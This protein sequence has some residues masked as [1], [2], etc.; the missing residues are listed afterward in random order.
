MPRAPRAFGAWWISC[1]LGVAGSAPAAAELAIFVPPP[2]FERTVAL[3]LHPPRH[4][5]PIPE[6]ALLLDAVEAHLSGRALRAGEEILFDATE[7]RVV[8]RAPFQS[9]DTLWLRYRTLPVTLAAAYGEVPAWAAGAAPP[10]EAEPVR[11]A[12]VGSAGIPGAGARAEVGGPHAVPDETAPAGGPK[13]DI[14]GSKSLVVESGSS[15]DAALRQSLDVSASGDLGGGVR[16]TAVLSDRDAPITNAGSTLDLQEID[17]VLVEVEHANATGRLGDYTL[18]QDI[19]RYGRFERRGS[20][21]HVEG[22]FAGNEVLASLAESKGRYH[23]VRLLGQEGRQGPYSLTDENGA[24]PVAVVSGSETVW[25]DGV[26]MQRGESA[27]YSVDYGRG[28][29]TFSP[30][31]VVV[32]DARIVVDFQIATVAY[33]RL[34]TRGAGSVRMGGLRLFGHAFREADDAARPTAGA[35]SAADEERLAGLGDAPDSAVALPSEHT[36]AGGGAEFQLGSVLKLEA[37]GAMSRLDRNRLS[38]RDDGDNRGQA[39]RWGAAL[40]PPLRLGARSLGALELAYAGERWQDGFEP[41]GRTE[42]PLFYEEW[43]LSPTRSIDGR[44]TQAWTLGLKPA[45]ALRVGGERA[46]LDTDDGFDAE[47]WRGTAEWSGRWR[48]RLRLERTAS[49]DADTAAVARPDGY[50][51]L[52]AYE[53][54]WSLRPDFTPSFHWQH[55]EFVPPG[56]APAE[57]RRGWSTGLRGERGL[58]GWTGSFGLRRDWN[59]TGTEWTDRSRTRDWRGEVRTALGPEASASLGLGRRVTEAAGGG[60]TTADNGFGRLTLGT[61]GARHEAAVEWTAEGAPWRLPEL[62]LVGEGAGSFDSLGHFTPGG[63]YRLE[64]REVVDSLRQLARGRLAYRAEWSLGSGGGG[65]RP[66]RLMTTVQSGAAQEGGLEPRTFLAIPRVLMTDRSIVTGNFLF[67]QEVQARTGRSAEWTLRLERQGRADRQTIGYS[68]AQN[69]WTEE[70]RVRWRLATRWNAEARATGSQRQGESATPSTQFSRDLR[71]WNTEGTLSFNPREAITVA[72]SAE[73]I[74]LTPAREPGLQAVRCGPRVTWNLGSR[75][76]LEGETR[77]APGLTAR[78]WPTLVPSEVQAAW[79][80]LSC[81][82]DFSYR[83]RAHGFLGVEWLARALPGERVTHTA[84]AEMR[85]YF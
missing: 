82:L 34:A 53:T 28:T 70:L 16:L 47:R 42:T 62:H 15:R 43:G 83:L 63:G 45:A 23:S 50:R 37:E 17:Q 35:L 85:A 40:T 71:S 58:W 4:S 19:G 72:G 30:R 20:G 8:L 33:T 41:V 52:R 14:T 5:Y 67:R 21:A 73:W 64:Y 66:L 12:A 31:R 76:R 13:L 7:R 49:H 84:R 18:R 78:A 32:A 57:R 60:R 46:F 11:L 36:L 38:T 24:A 59:L 51:E 77:W 3:V 2:A 44:R 61:W 25:L 56:E 75:S 9:G 55:D 22:R 39:Q 74:A 65:G 79:D 27:D 69:G 68:E 1:A 10:E 48:Q 81:R 29:L 26:R 6:E 80:R 54:E